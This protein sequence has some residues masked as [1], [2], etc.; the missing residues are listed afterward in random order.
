MADALSTFRADPVL[1]IERVLHDPETGQP[2]KLL[3]AERAFLKYAFTTGP[4][5][6]LLYPE[7][8]FGAPKK[9]GK[10]GFAALVVLTVVLLHGGRFGE[11]YTLANDLEQATGRVFQAIRR[12]VEASP[13]LRNEAK[14]TADKIVSPSFY[15]ATITAVASDYQSA[16]G[17]NPT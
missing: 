8:I 1:F 13:L 16:A 15:N 11:A 4:D 3:S 10:T 6:K 14:V 2:F 12:I 5:G 7:L 9:S 17:A